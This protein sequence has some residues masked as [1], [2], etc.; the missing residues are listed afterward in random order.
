M[1]SV[2]FASNAPPFTVRL[3]YSSMPCPNMLYL[4]QFSTIEASSTECN[5]S[6]GHEGD[7]GRDTSDIGFSS[8]V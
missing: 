2:G 3:L 5:G 1:S 7:A 6:S 4:L 8:A